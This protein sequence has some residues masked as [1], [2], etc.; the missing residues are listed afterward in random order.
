[1]HPATH[2]FALCGLGIQFPRLSDPFKA[3]EEYAYKLHR[4]TNSHCE[5]LRAEVK[6]MMEGQG[7][8][9]FCTVSK[10]AS[11]AMTGERF[12]TITPVEEPPWSGKNHRRRC[13]DFLKQYPGLKNMKPMEVPW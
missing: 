6:D 2:Y 10:L 11:D 3:G 5:A 4:G 8:L 9:H 1:M 7:N 12:N 13:D